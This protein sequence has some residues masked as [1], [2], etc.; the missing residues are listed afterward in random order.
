MN[1]LIEAELLEEFK[2]DSEIYKV[3]DSNNSKP[4]KLLKT[5]II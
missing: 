2:F 5:S 4:S 1:N 3:N